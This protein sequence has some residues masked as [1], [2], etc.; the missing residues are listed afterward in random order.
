MR[1]SEHLGSPAVYVATI[2]RADALRHVEWHIVEREREIVI[3]AARPKLWCKDQ[4]RLRELAEEY[5]AE[6]K[7]ATPN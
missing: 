3:R 2:A 6:I 4:G 5:R 7:A 1:Y